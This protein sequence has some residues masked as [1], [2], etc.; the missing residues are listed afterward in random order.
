MVALWNT[1]LPSAESAESAEGRM[2]VGGGV[3]EGLGGGRLVWV[4][5]GLV[6]YDVFFL[7]LG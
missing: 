3:E 2:Q 6:W 5:V 4:R 7:N 1:E